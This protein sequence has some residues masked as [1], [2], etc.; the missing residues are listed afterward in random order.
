[1]E[2]R[3]FFL[4]ALD[5]M[6]TLCEQAR[7]RSS[8]EL[9]TLPQ[10]PSDE[11]GGLVPAIMDASDVASDGT[12]FVVRRGG[13]V[14]ALFGIGSK[15]ED[16]WARIDGRASVSEIA[17]ALTT[18]WN[19]SAETAFGRTRRVILLLVDKGICLPRNPLY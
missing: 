11:L 4:Y 14:E 5:E 3:S 7:G 1:M 17:D 6:L 2:R 12:D 9:S 16:V 13:R 10:L 18:H 19:E 8:F 15:E